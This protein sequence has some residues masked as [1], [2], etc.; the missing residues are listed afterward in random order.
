M[1]VLSHEE[2]GGE[3]GMPLNETA[4]G[5]EAPEQGD[6]KPIPEDTYQVV[7]KDVDE[8]IMKKYKSD[9]DDAFYHFKFAIL[10]EGE[11]VQGQIVSTFCGRKWFGGSKK[12]SPSKLVSLVK[13]VY[14]HYY[15]KLS[16]VE[17]E[18]EDMTLP[19]INDLI[20]KQLRI[21]VK[22]ND[23]K[24]N[25]KVTDF[26]AVKK[27]LEI[28]ESVTIA[29]VPKKMLPKNR[30]DDPEEDEPEAKEEAKP[31]KEKKAEPESEVKTEEKGKSDLPF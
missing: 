16:I 25:N 5:V 7:I 4:H 20:G 23:D 18:A 9:E 10:D 29:K 17:I 6:W 15:P 12:Y 22:L 30:Q 13:A 27:E 26:M 21:I 14:A 3:E 28:P 1:I 2:K 19:V 8:K 11:E 31:A 24:T